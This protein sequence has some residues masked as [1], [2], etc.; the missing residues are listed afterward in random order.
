MEV[1]PNRAGNFPVTRI[2]GH[3]KVD[4]FLK[5]RGDSSSKRT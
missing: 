3:P 1:L 2:A 5:H 4:E